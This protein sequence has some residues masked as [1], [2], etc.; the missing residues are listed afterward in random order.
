MRD[1]YV[2]DVVVYAYN[3]KTY[4]SYL[5]QIIARS[6]KH[7]WTFNHIGELRATEEKYADRDINVI[8]IILSREK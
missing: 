8:G 2:N 4:L 6:C 1:F 3:E 7:R 5:E